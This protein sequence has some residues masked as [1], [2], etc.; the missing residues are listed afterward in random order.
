M[1]AHH[2]Q[3]RGN[4]APWPAKAKT[5]GSNAR[6]KHAGLHIQLHGACANNTATQNPRT[7]I[8]QHARVHRIIRIDNRDGVAA[9]I[10]KQFRLGV[11]VGL[12]VAVVIQM[13]A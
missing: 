3:A 10:F 12:H 2:W 13:I 8:A 6:L 7:A 1:A 11:G 9:K 4:F 5:H